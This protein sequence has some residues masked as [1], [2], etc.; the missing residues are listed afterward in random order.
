MADVQHASLTGSSLHSSKIVTFTGDASA[1]TPTETGIIVA[2]TDVTPNKLY[3]TT[4]LSAGNVVE[5]G[6]STAGAAGTLVIDT[7][8]TNA[9]EISD[10]ADVFINNTGTS[11]AAVLDFTFDIPTATEITGTRTDSISQYA[12]AKRFVSFRIGDD[13]AWNGQLP[14]NTL[15]VDLRISFWQEND[16]TPHQGIGFLAIGFKEFNNDASHWGSII[17]DSSWNWWGSGPSGWNWHFVSPALT[18]DLTGTDGT[19]NRMNFNFYRDGAAAYMSV[20]NRGGS[21]LNF[22]AEMT[23]ITGTP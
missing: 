6:T 20:E 4:G 21:V 22:Y 18:T 1:Y 23:C 2:K 3:R 14:N 19:D 7:I 16:I 11:S 8:T 15:M 12:E 13:E 17:Y 5:I 10:S 9:V